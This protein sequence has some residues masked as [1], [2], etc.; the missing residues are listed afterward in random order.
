M[1]RY[2]YTAKT[3]PAKTI[4][5]NIDAESNQDAVNKL[6]R[7]GYYPV[8]VEIENLAAL[9]KEDFLSFRRL[10]NKDIT[11]F[12]RQLS[13]LIESGVNIL[14]ALNIVSGQTENKYLK[15][16][17]V[18]VISRIKDGMPL[19][20]TLSKYPNL[21]S[22]LYTSMIR[23]GETGG[24]LEQTLRR[25]ADY[26]E[27]EEEFKNSIRSALTYPFFIVGVGVLTVVVLLTFVI[28]R[29]VSM[30]EDMGQALPLPTKML[31][32]TSAFLRSYW[33]LVLSFLAVLV[34]V[35][36][37]AHATIHGKAVLDKLKLKLP[38][39]GDII[40][41]SEVSRLTRTL[42]VLL[43][44]GVTIVQALEVSSSVV[45]NEVVRAQVVIFKDKI[46]Q[47]DSLANCLKASGVFPQFVANI[48]SIGEETG[49]LEKSLL[50][51]ADDY[52]RT[53][54]RSLKD[55]SRLLEPIII[56][57]MGLIVGFIVLSMLL[58]IF[59]INLMAR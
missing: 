19:S 25:M 24:A 27:K 21:F 51:V 36:Q 14:S 37:R 9:E 2:N 10:S 12:T 59:Q 52:E 35:M 43:S 6:S 1:P 55:L 53:V 29:L 34:F 49:T 23:S 50:R 33:W 47:G 45:Q 4:R 22:G 3:G 17:L 44:S 39:L 58:P 40:L 28:P 8:S 13:T 32:D 7:M 16:V 57:A 11:L 41:K 26:M 38:V 54:D 31:I 20:E 56:V 18:D 5:G 30:F 48:L 15:A 42:S 46:S